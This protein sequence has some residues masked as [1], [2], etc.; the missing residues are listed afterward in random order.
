MGQFNQSEPTTRT[1]YDEPSRVLDWALRYA[2]LD[3]YVFPCR[4]KKPRTEHGVDDASNDPKLIEDW[5][6][7]WPEAQIGV[8]CKKSGFDVLDTDRQVGPDG[9]VEKDGEL[10]FVELAGDRSDSAALQA[11]TPRGGRHR[12]YAADPE[13]A[14]AGTT[15]V[16]P[17]IDLRTAG[18]NNYVILPNGR[19]NREWLNDK[20]WNAELVPMPEWIREELGSST[21]STSRGPSKSGTTASASRTRSAHRLPLTD[22][23][24][25]DIRAALCHLDNRERPAWLEIC[26]ALRSTSDPD[27][28]YALWTEWSRTKWKRDQNQEVVRDA[29]GRCIPENGVE[30]KFNEQ[31]QRK[32]WDHALESR[33]DASEISLSTLFYR[34]K[35]HGYRG[36]EADASGSGDDWQEYGIGELAKLPP[37]E[38]AV[39][40][41][42]PLA[43]VTLLAGH[44]GVGKSYLALDLALRTTHGKDEWLGADIS[45]HGPVVY[46]AM[47]GLAG[48]AGRLRAWQAHHPAER[49]V[50]V[51]KVVDANKSGEAAPLSPAGVK[52]TMRRLRDWAKCNGAPRIVIVDTLTLATEGDEND[53]ATVRSALSVAVQIAAEFG[54]A[55]ILVHHLR[56]DRPG[57]R[58]RLDI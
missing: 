43:S 22:T 56:K 40:D 36:L 30:P 54:C 12:F 5:W 58:E 57:A 31:D 19:D 33:A 9:K 42:V 16:R 27:L 29:A 25:L 13:R 4:D 39:E 52:A 1:R 34:A 8:S 45:G 48:F 17:G 2:G 11:T 53:A 50:H 18:S 20:P 44:P 38:W 6:G 15:S 35:E 21:S 10:V 32:T 26:F 23:Q 24:V 37:V 51:M 14:I 46:L 55:V 41:L 7:M 47:E 28:A 49:E 3:W